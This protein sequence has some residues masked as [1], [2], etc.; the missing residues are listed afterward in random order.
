MNVVRLIETKK[1]G[2]VLSSGEIEEVVAGFTA[3]EVS[4]YQMAALL[5]AVWFRGMDPDEVTALTGAML[6][7]GE[8]LELD[9]LAP[10]ADK[11]STGGVGDKVSLLLA[12]LAAACGLRVPMLSGRGLG[13]TGGT[14]D[15]LEAIPGYRIDLDNDAFIGTVADV[16]CA[17]I[18]QGPGI[19][20]ADGRIYAL[21]DVTG[22]V[23]CIPLITASIMSKKL[24][25][26]PQ[27]IVIDLKVGSGAFMTSMD[28]ARALAE[29]L[30]R[31]GGAWQRRM[32][33]IFSDM[34]Q[35]L[36][37]AVGHAN[38]TVEAF[39]ALRPGG[40]TAA[41]ADLTA[42]TEALV[43]EMILTAGQAPDREAAAAQVRK[44]WDD[45]S[46]LATLSAWVEAQGG[47]LD[48]DDAD[49][50]LDLAPRALAVEAPRAGWIGEIA[51]RELGGAL[52][53]IGGARLRVEDALD[54][55]AGIDFTVRRGDRVEA[56]EPLAW[57]R[58]RDADAAPGAAARVVA[59]VAVDEAPSPAPDLVLGRLA[60]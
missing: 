59:A 29:A 52:A 42:L 39:A 50:G 5:M 25:A 8:Q 18:G 11:H 31:I 20:P 44:V 30:V 45:G 27:T 35:P 12:P 34:S 3:G 23:D 57:I 47:R 36:G 46:A 38:E 13:H 32:A 56:G 28:E 43:A 37:V 16:G 17:I 41:P 1:R 10:T 21:R 60:G 53:E 58:S 26:G 24:A 14:L 48:P 7:S 9:H 19:A 54:L 33:V 22:T 40:R 6:R 49:F 51:C 55:S 4:R 2:G 15:K